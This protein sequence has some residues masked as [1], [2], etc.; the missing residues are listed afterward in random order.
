[1]FALFRI[2]LFGLVRRQFP[3]ML[4]TS[5]GIG[6]AVA[7]LVTL[8]GFFAATEAAMTRQAIADV[9]VDWQIQLAPGADPNAAI[10]ELASSPGYSRAVQAGYFDTP[11]F[12]AQSGGTVQTT[13]KGVV[14]GLGPGYRDAFST[15]I[16]DL[17]GKGNVVLAQQTAANLHAAPGTTVTIVR[18]GMNTANVKVEAI[19]DLP[20][21]DSLFQAIGVPA[22]S[23]PQAPPDNVLILPLDQWHALF[24]PV[25]NTSSNALHVQI[26]AM[27][28]HQLPASP[29]DAFTTVSRQA[30]NY[31]SRLAG[32]G[33][34]GDNLGARL[35]VA[36]SDALYARVLFLFLGLPGA[37]L[38]ILLTAAV[39]ASGASRR[40]RDQAL[41]RIRG[42]STA[43]LLRL[44]AVEGAVV[45][46]WGSILGLALGSL[47]VRL[48]FGRWGFGTSI[49]SSVLWGGIAAAGGVLLALALL[50]I[51]SWRDARLE[52]VSRARIGVRRRRVPIWEILGVD[53]I[54]L[55]ISGF[56]YWQASRKGYQLVL[57]PEGVPAVSVSY[58]SFFAPLLLWSGVALLAFRLIR[59]FLG[60]NGNLLTPL[61]R[62]LGS[63]LAPLVSASISRQRPR[64]ATGL[65]LIGLA[66]AFSVSTSIFNAT[67][68]RQALV[69]AEL[70]NGADV[71]VTGGAAADLSARQR[72]IASLPGVQAVEA[73]Q[74]RFAY[75]GTDLQDIYGINPSSLTNAARLSDSYF[76]GGT[77]AEEMRLLANTPDGVLVSP[78]TVTDFQLQ[79]GDM[80]K[81]RLQ[82]AVDQQYRVVPF[83][84]VGIAREFPTAPSDSFLV[85]N[86][87][88]IAKVTG[89][90]SVETLL[91]KTS[92]PPAQVA[93][94]VRTALGGVSG[95]T[96][97]DIQ[98]QRNVIRSGLTA[99]S[100]HGLTSIE[101]IFAVAISAAGAG[102][103][104]ALGLN[105]SR[106]TLAIATALGATPRQ[107]GS[108]VW[109]EA[110][111]LFLG[112]LGGGAALG[113]GV[114]R[115]L[116]DLLTHVFDPPPEGMTV[117]WLYLGLVVV[118]TTSAI[119][120][121][122]QLIIRIG[123]R[124]VLTTIR[125]L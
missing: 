42:A 95:A 27:I 106:R 55:A 110:G 113:W 44:S 21:A 117:P 35:D 63:H 125:S 57:A 107:L 16:R 36:R 78:E 109:S 116:I 38:A 41:L 29:T 87:S 73:M 51:P 7:F 17:I 99:V 82:S 30:R 123:Q 88:Y 3:R 62:P 18:P 102:L 53:F 77:A 105:E 92:D 60:R 33:I 37:V 59:L 49:S 68:E 112:G 19:V 80:I 97:H 114:A 84:Y 93:A 108:F 75:V 25:A 90:P 1:M 47:I 64:I 94:Q 22:G 4:A 86:A 15:E 58:T 119:A 121:A 70:S 10:S 52:S 6:V 34:V 98:E 50:V 31:E 118:V 24:D 40:R 91:V 61:V 69:D 67:Y 120:V 122:S 13:G 48:T 85:A 26:H 20:F 28:M 2:W 104:L 124:D 12:E 71:T 89:S 76:V 65:V 81:L 100:L 101:L 32:A 115:M 5:V 79:R 111:L 14:L 56:I 9:P 43:Q 66:I 72:E 45:G 23:S 39:I 54:L 11:G 83:H 103:V 46:V 74:H 8:A 96:V